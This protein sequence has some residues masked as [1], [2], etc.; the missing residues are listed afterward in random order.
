MID[1]EPMVRMLIFEVLEEAGFR[2]IEAEDG[3]S[4]LK[5]LEQQPGIDLLITDFG[6]PGGMTELAAKITE[7]IDS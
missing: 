6:L 3:P 1:D 7:M 5:L 4:G 2:S